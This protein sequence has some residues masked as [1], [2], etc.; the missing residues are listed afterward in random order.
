MFT[1]KSVF[2]DKIRIEVETQIF[3][4]VAKTLIMPNRVAMTIS[5]PAQVHFYKNIIR[6]LERKSIE[7]RLLFRDYSE[8]LE[9]VEECGYTGFVFSRVK[10]NWDRIYKLPF[11]VLRARKYLKGFK[12]DLVIG[13]EVYAPYIAKLLGSRSFVFYDSEPRTSKFLA[14]Q[15]RAY[16]PFVDAILT[17]SSFMD[18]LGKKHLKVESFKELAYLHPKYFKP[19]RTVLDDAGV[20]ENE[21]VLLRFNAFNAAHDIGIGGFSVGDRI[22]LV[23]ELEKHAKVLISSEAKLPEKLEKYRL[24][25]PKSKIHDVI[26]H[27]KLLVADTG[28]MTTE[29]A[30]L[31]TPAVACHKFMWKMGNFIELEKKY[32]LIYNYRDPEMAIKKALELVMEDGLKEEW[33]KKRE[34][35]LKDKIDI[36][37][38]MVWFIENYPES[39]EEFKRNPEIQYR[40]R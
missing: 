7:I 32:G 5:T 29:A 1:E 22:R 13:F 4:I 20:Y 2:E 3:K 40:F 27:A 38:F 11:D 35:L 25:V 8:T 12:P 30:V 10:T 36:T 26:Y 21:Y 15:I 39:L 24:P 37:A 31:G 9:V 17:P 6:G 23:R 34:K 33:R 28:T 16:I 19:D 18:N 14:I